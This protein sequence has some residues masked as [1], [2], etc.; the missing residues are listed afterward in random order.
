MAGRGRQFS[1][2]GAFGSKAAARSKE[3]AVGG[4]I[5]PTMI[6]G[7]R[8]FVV[9]SRNQSFPAGLAP[10]PR[11]A[12]AATYGMA[13]D[14]EYGLRE[15]TGRDPVIKRKLTPEELSRLE[16]IF[17]TAFPER[18]K[19]VTRRTPGPNPGRPVEVYRRVLRIEAV[20]GRGR[21]AGQRFYHPFKVPARVYGLS[22]GDLLV[23]TRRL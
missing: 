9:M 16:T 22:N 6:R 1:F 5:K 2:H 8:R 4:F 17:R 18:A 13:G 21:Y 19:E 7:H 12:R 20:K 14:P 23:T 10:R 11:P 3:R 15:A